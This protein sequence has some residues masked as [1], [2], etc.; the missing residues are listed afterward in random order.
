[1]SIPLIEALRMVEL[2]P[3]RVYRERVNGKTVVVQVIHE[4]GDEPTPEQPGG[5]IIQAELGPISL[6]DPPFIPDD[7]AAEFPSPIIVYGS[8]SAAGTAATA[9]PSSTSGTGSPGAYSCRERYAGGLA[10]GS[11]SAN[12][13]TLRSTRFT[14]Q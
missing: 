12:T 1:M 11:G 7:E 13:S 5:F 2:E 4:S 9:V 3:G 6:P 10:V 14:T 8:N